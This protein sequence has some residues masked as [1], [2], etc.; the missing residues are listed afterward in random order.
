MST[1]VVGGHILL[2]EAL[3]FVGSSVSVTPTIGTE[4]VAAGRDKAVAS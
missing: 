2:V 1:E 3:T 4:G